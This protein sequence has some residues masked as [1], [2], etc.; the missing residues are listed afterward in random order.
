MNKLTEIHKITMKI[1]WC[2]GREWANVSPRYAER[3]Q[4]VATS[5]AVQPRGSAHR[6]I[7]VLVLITKRISDTAYY[8]RHLYADSKRVYSPAQTLL[9]LATVAAYSCFTQSQL[10]TQEGGLLPGA[11]RAQCGVVVVDKRS[12]GLLKIR[13]KQQGGC[14]FEDALGT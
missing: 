3:S 12:A 8:R 2:E 4:V 6:H 7:P 10:S 14:H 5:T 13:C 9:P 11:Q 1:H